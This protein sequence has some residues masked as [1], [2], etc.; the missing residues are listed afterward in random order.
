MKSAICLFGIVGG[1][2]GKNGAGR[3]IPFKK[4]YETYKK[5]II[6]I[7]N[8][9]VFIHSWSC[10]LKDELVDLYKPKKYV[11]EKQKQFTEEVKLFKRPG[12]SF[13]SLSKWNSL[14]QSSGLRKEYE[15]EHNFKYDWVMFV[16]LDLLFY[17][18]MNFSTYKL[19]H[20]HVP[21][22]NTPQGLPGKPR[23]KAD[24]SNRTRKR[25]GFSDMWYLG[26]SKIADDFMDIYEGIVAG[27]YRVGQ[28]AAAHDCLI[29]K[30]YKKKDFRYI[31]YTYFDFDIYRWRV[32][33]NF[34]K[35]GDGKI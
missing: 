9:D 19:N 23:I 29:K 5:H 20:L 35:K 21:H 6:D 18:D 15:K 25:D 30:G 27:K 33:R 3:Y 14:G 28:H 31:L 11:F 1:T 7:N 22:W 32:L 16:R 34:Y 26:N 17:V 2:D 8:A 10:D 13:R 24:R 4:C 12:A